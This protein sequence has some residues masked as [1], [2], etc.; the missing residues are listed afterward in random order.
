[1]NISVHVLSWLLHVLLDNSRRG[2]TTE[3]RLKIV[4]QC[5]LCSLTQTDLSATSGRA[6]GKHKGGDT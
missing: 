1:M 2:Q 6:S 3:V 5:A 4:E